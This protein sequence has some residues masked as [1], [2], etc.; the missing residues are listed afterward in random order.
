MLLTHR[1]LQ[2]REHA[3]VSKWRSFNLYGA[4]STYLRTG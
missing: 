3:R 2:R 4:E 1:Q